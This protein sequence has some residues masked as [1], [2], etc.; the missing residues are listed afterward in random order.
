MSDVNANES[1]YGGSQSESQTTLM[2][3]EHSM[4]NMILISSDDEPSIMNSPADAVYHVACN[5]QD[6]ERVLSLVAR[7]TSIDFAAALH[8]PLRTVLLLTK[9]G[10]PRHSIVAAN[11]WRASLKNYIPSHPEI[12][13]TFFMNTSS[14]SHTPPAT[15]S[16]TAL[17]ATTPESTTEFVPQLTDCASAMPLV[18]FNPIPPP[19]PYEDD[20]ISA[21][22]ADDPSG[23]GLNSAAASRKDVAAALNLTES[24]VSQLVKIGMPLHSVAAAKEWRMKRQRSNGADAEAA[25][26]AT[27]TSGAAGDP[28]ALFAAPTFALIT[29]STQRRLR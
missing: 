13:K 1:F 2:P 25:E 20:D 24:R 4:S 26:A 19:I 28:H 29:Q 12:P 3:K 6:P 7:P 23:S 18:S 16:P 22:P 17:N 15:R 21:G 27:C 10:M 11:E 8:V 9:M 14:N 5:H